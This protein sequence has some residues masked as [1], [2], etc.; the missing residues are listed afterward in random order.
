M[1]VLIIGSGGREH[2]LAWR[3]A[4][5][6]GVGEVLACPGNPGIASVARLHPSP[7]GEAGLADLAERER[8]DLTI[9]GPELPL[10]EGVV[11]LF[12][13]RGLPIVG[14]SKGAASLETSKGFAKMFMARH[15]VPTAR[16]RVCASEDEARTVVSRGELGL[17]VVVKAD[18]LAAGKGVVVAPDR[19]AA[20]EAIAAMMRDRRFGSAGARVVLEECLDGPELSLFVLSDGERVV[21]LGTAQ[22][23]KRAFDE[24]RGPNTG[25]MGAFAPSPLADASLQDC[26]LR[27]IVEPVIRGMRDEGTPYAGFLYCGLM[28]TTDGPKVIEFNVRFGDPEAQVV[29]PLLTGDVIGALGAAA[30][31]DLRGARL[32]IAQERTVGVVVA[33]GGYPDHYQT[34]LPI[35]GVDEAEALPGVVV[36]HAGTALSD[37]RLVTAGGRVLT[38]V[39]IGDD[40][41]SARAR[42]YEGASHIRFQGLHMRRDIGLKAV[43]A[44]GRA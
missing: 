38:V 14:P 36:F 31:G 33:S 12:R 37:G 20:F 18:G 19:E 41:Q 8:V 34:G 28:L 26:V 17:P 21:P 2:A 11:D 16:Y 4:R 42:A 1:K 35:L 10:S 27:E 3:V 32:G 25:G 24:D 43:T 30:A 5:E 7:P 29:L 6:P 15:G 9:V 23:H 40:F 44:T 13:A 22:D 39:A